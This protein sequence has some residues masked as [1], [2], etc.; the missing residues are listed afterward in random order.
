GRRLGRAALDPAVPSITEFVRTMTPAQVQHLERK[1]EKS[2]QEFRKRYLS[3][4]PK[5]RREAP[6]PPM[7]ERAE[8]M[9]GDLDGSQRAWL[10]R[11]IAA[12]PYDPERW[13]AER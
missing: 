11:S 9:Y 7:R 3:S 2:N 10:A 4:D 6:L 8:M 13:N 12:S 5:E 1:F